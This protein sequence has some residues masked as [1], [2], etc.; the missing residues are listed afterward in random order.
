[1]LTDRLKL[2]RVCVCVCLQIYMQLNVRV[3]LVGLEIWTQQNLISTEGAAGEVLSRFTQWREKALLPR[4]RHDSAQLILSAM[5]HAH[6]HAH[7]QVKLD[8]CSLVPGRGALEEP[9]EWPSSPPC[10]PGATGAASTR[11]A[12]ARPSPRPPP[13]PGPV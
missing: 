8:D 11:C 5:T 2:M 1:M 12:A 7:T 13:C 10:A 9:L 4:R 6:P 3:V